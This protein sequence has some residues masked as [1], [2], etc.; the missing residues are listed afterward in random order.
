MSYG[1]QATAGSTG[2]K[3]GV[4]T[5]VTADTGAAQLFSLRP[6]LAH[7]AISVSST[8][9][10]TCDYV[11]VTITGHSPGDSPV[12]PPAGRSLTLSM[13]PA[14]AVWQ[15]T[16]VTGTGGWTPSGSTATYLWPGGVETSFTVR[17]RQYATGTI[18]INLNDGS[19]VKES[20]LASEDPNITFVSSSFRISNGA[21]QP[22]NIGTQIS[23]KGSNTGFGA[24][25]LYL[26]AINASQNGA[27][28]TLLNASSQMTV[29]VSAQCNNPASCTRNVTVTSIDGSG[30]VVDSKSFTP[31]GA[32]PP[33][34]GAAMTFKVTSANAEAPF[35]LS[36][37]DAGQITLQ[38]R[39]Q[40]TG[41]SPATYV[42]GTSNAFVVR[43][44]GIAFPGIHHANL[45]SGPTGA[46]FP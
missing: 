32:F 24:Q 34:G 20:L 5:G 2:N 9:V 14:T 25:A 30:A 23:G 10:A 39:A 40:I 19:G 6:G 7:Y 12:S 18:N 15:A 28:G 11:D 13:S 21:G 35:L 45:A 42:Q 1:A 46:L 38:F 43:P 41:S 16:L 8:S 17:L 3:T 29:E 33:G 22:T 26:Q 4:A 36:Y 37:D 31:N 44:F 27:C